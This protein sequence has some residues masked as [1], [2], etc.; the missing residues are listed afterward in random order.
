MQK[1]KKV[2]IKLGL[3]FLVSV[4]LVSLVPTVR[5]DTQVFAKDDYTASGGRE[6]HAR[7]QGHLVFADGYSGWGIYTLFLGGCYTDPP[8]Y[9]D[10]TRVRTYIYIT[11]HYKRI[12]W[13]YGQ[14]PEYYYW[15]GAPPLNFIQ[16]NGICSYG[17]STPSTVTWSAQIGASYEGFSMSIGFQHTPN[18]YYSWG[19]AS[20]ISGDY[21]YYGYFFSQYIGDIPSPHSYQSLLKLDVSNSLANDY[22]YGVFENQQYGYSYL[23]IT[24]IQIKLV[25]KFDYRSWWTWWQY[26]S[27]YTGDLHDDP[28][29]LPEILLYP[30]QVNL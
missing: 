28:L 18:P 7:A 27:T 14:Y 3:I 30:G 8:W 15:W 21:R 5:A 23:Y 6:A 13:H 4:V 20:S 29:D 25:W 12:Y 10:G 11:A 9:T 2:V 26:G 22:F 16:W 17:A 24:G 1:T 19:G